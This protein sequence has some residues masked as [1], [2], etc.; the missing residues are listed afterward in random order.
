MSTERA[1]AMQSAAASAMQMFSQ[2][3]S[4]GKVDMSGM[5]SL[6]KNLM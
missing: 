5:L 3:Q 2:Y 1:T 6:A 4:K